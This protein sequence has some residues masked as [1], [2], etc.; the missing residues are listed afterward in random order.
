MVRRRRGDTSD[1]EGRLRIARGHV[2]YARE[3]VRHRVQGAEDDASSALS[4]RLPVRAAGR[5]RGSVRRQIHAAHELQRLQPARPHLSGRPR[6]GAGDHRG[7]RRD[8]R[9][10]E[11][12]PNEG[13]S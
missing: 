4:G 3:D 8:I 1:A 13:G 9:H 6:D 12:P 5:G 11:G 2:T 10:F 7:D